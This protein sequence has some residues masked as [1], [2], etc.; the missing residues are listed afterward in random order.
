M[1]REVGFGTFE[2]PR[3]GFIAL[4]AEDL[5]RPNSRCP[6][7]SGIRSSL[8]MSMWIRS[9]GAECC[10]VP[11]AARLLASYRESGVLIEVAQQLHLVSA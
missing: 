11:L 5:S 1:G 4:I 10:R 8:V 6:P 2:E 7:P 3:V 9:P